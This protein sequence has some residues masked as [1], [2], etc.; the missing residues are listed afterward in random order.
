MES[1]SSAGEPLSPA[2]SLRALRR[3]LA[4]ASEIATIL[5]AS[6]FG[7]LVAALG[8]RACVSLR[9]RV[10]CSLRLRQCP[11]HVAMDTP[12]PERMRLVL[13]RL[14]PTF[15]KAG[16]MLALR[17]DYVPLAYADA[18]RP[19]HANAQSFSGA[20][21]RRVI[22]REL[23][24][25]IERLFAEFEPAPF[26]AASLSQVHRARLPDGRR[27]AV[28]VQRPGIQEQIESDLALLSVLA[29]RLQRR[30]RRALAFRPSDAVDEFAQ[31]TRRELDFRN[32]AV[33]AE[34]MRSAFT[35]RDDVVIP[36]V[37]GELSGARVLTTE[38]VDGRSPGPAGELRAAG[39]DPDALI[40]TGASAM[41]T[42]IFEHGLFHADPHPGNLLFLG[43]D[44]VC[45]LDFGMVGQLGRRD[46]RR[47][48]FVLWALAD[49]DFGGVADRLLRIS[50]RRPGANPERFRR[51]VADAVADWYGD[52]SADYSIARLLLRYLSLG[53]GFG[54]VFPRELML[55]ARAL[56]NLESTATVIDEDFSLQTVARELLPQLRRS[57]LGD[58]ASPAD[59]WARHRFDYLDLALDLP[60][61][62]PELLAQVT[63]SSHDDG[64]DAP[65]PRRIGQRWLALWTFAIGALAGSAI[66][67]RHRPIS[68]RRSPR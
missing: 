2:H 49:G 31:Y 29:G 5:S 1:H 62:V 4:R 55:L 39:L 38:L 7:W 6:G 23:E 64:A 44:R 11:H 10:I 26:A 52:R 17:P 51:A 16:Q 42:Q 30:S 20:E 46:R 66:A 21:A 60:D 43:G 24:A 3:Q 25:P 22:E 59:A 36:E 13:E 48:A 61:L 56:V 68:R 27:V 57:L 14:G 32:E 33:T 67:A 35:D 37:M 50:T 15:V 58:V 65:T 9:C 40:S 47:M 53:G 41:F 45:F 54:I 12:L 34:R 18:L 19:L 8:L 63:E 28:K